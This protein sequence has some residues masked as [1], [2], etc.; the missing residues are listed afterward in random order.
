MILSRS[1]LWSSKSTKEWKKMRNN[2]MT[3]YLSKLKAGTDKENLNI[4]TESEYRMIGVDMVSQVSSS[5]DMIKNN[6]H[7][8]KSKGTNSISSILISLIKKK[9][10]SIT[11]NRLKIQ[12]IWWLS[13]RLV[14]HIRTLVL[15]FL[16]NSGILLENLDSK[17][18]L[19][20]VFCNFI[21]TSKNLNLEYDFLINLVYSEI[22]IF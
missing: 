2:L 8:N 20:K 6:H 22:F 11:C 5:K 13:S 16:E 21:L 9:L 10:L 12:V 4:S 15:K 18:Y 1:K 14:H 3:G 7:Q 17:P 19:R